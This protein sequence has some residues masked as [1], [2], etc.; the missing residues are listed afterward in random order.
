LAIVKHL[1]ADYVYLCLILTQHNP[2][3]PVTMQ[4]HNLH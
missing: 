2:V 4:C 3:E 1:N